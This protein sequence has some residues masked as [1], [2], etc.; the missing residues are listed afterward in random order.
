[1]KF[2]YWGIGIW[3][4]AGILD[5]AAMP[6]VGRVLDWPG[7]IGKDNREIADSTKS[8]WR[9]VGRLNYSGYGVYGYCTGT[10]IA[11]KIV[12]T[13]AHC[14]FD[15]RT[16]AEGYKRL[17]VKDYHFALGMA[18]DQFVELG[19][20]DCVHIPPEF[21]PNK[22]QA[23]SDVYSD[24]AIVILKE[25]MHEPPIEFADDDALTEDAV[26]AHAGYGR[27]RPYLLS[28]HKDC[29]IL[30]SSENVVLTNCDSNF[31]QSGGPILIEQ[32]GKVKIAAIM[33][34]VMERLANWAVSIGSV[35]KLAEDTSCNTKT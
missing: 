22:S 4:V 3:C 30:S 9:S 21:D 17:P 7:I 27:D 33:S 16:E 19:Q 29:R 20:I 15:R 26:V 34:R 23:L 12:V 18:R 35:R 6:A 24:V 32:D 2:I 28:V 13:A 14:F 1:M 11:P 25:P 8:P 10:L 5:F 31:G